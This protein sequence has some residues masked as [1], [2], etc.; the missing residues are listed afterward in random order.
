MD[1]STANL[2]G[3]LVRVSNGMALGLFSSLIIGL[4][5][6]Q[7]GDALSVRIL[8]VMGRSAQLLMGPAIGA[9]V[10]WSVGASPL[11]LFSSVI[12]G[13]IGAGTFSFDGG[14]V[15]AV[16]GEPVGALVASLAGAE[17]S[18]LISGRT[19]VDIVLVP[20]GTIAAGGLAGLFAGP[21]IARGLYWLGGIVNAA[22]ALQPIPMGIAVSV[23]MGLVL[24][25]P[26]SSAA[27]AIS[28]GLSGL[29]A[30][31]STVGCC[32]QM[33]GFAVAG[34]CDNGVGGLLSQG[35]G[36]SMIQMPNIIRNPWIWL[37]PTL[38]SAVL[39]PFS[40]V[41]FKMEN[42][43]IG[44]GM[45]TSGLVGQ[46]S[47]L[48]VMGAAAWPGIIVLHFAGPALLSLLFTRVL[49]RAGLVKAGDMRL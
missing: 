39:G 24:T 12:T 47:A 29:A 31:A 43:S 19:G 2:R 20:A 8:V 18:R 14:A 15:S 45:G 17:F 37:P 38:A 46:V 49:R 34:Y 13:A 27:L 7:A 28:L 25:L 4:I 21:A 5:L 16:V 44:A 33:V 42:S 30:G 23:I 32:C 36:T 26:I 3:Y 40:T 48:G 41:V 22:T 10:A 9:G 6:R 35:L 11:G 1:K